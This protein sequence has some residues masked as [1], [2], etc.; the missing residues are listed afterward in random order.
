[1]AIL[2]QT[3]VRTIAV[4]SGKGGVGKTNVVANL[5]IALQKEGCKVLILDA[6]LGLSNIDVLLHLAPKYNIQHVLDGEMKLKDIM[7]E[8]PYGIK[9][10]PATSGVQEMTSLDE[11]QR[12]RF[13]EEFE[14]LEEDI[15]VLLIDTAA[16]ISE[17]VAFFCIAAQ[18]II[19]V[20]SPDPTSIA[21]AYALIK[22]LYTRY[23][24][25][26]LNV[27]VNSAE[28]ETEAKEVFKRLLTAAEK[29]LHISLDYL[30]FI[31][32]DNAVVKAVRAQKAFVEAFPDSKAS[33]K[34]ASL[35]TKI[36]SKS[37][38][39]VKGSLQ[40]FIGNLLSS[41]SETVKK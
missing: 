19:I 37:K 7:V 17:N 5:A 38:I 20:T 29:F 32:R 31:P 13:L 23:Q 35:A 25:K 26:S 21:D 34:V 10:L 36:L 18:E 11:F 14:S 1:M 15:N 22:V 30:G 27:L 40:F 4:A 8:G 9:V 12:L 2:G 6:D 39:R 41:S 33:K 16:G 24:E 3:H 28:D